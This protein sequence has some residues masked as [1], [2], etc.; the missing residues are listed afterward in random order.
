M[1]LR[2][3][4]PA[5]ILS[6]VLLATIVVAVLCLSLALN[7]HTQMDMI[8]TATIPEIPNTIPTMTPTGTA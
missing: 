4:S 1:A 6:T 7:I 3:S 2:A 5:N 8:P